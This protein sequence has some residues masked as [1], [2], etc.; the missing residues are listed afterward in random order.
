VLAGLD[1]LPDAERLAQLYSQAAALVHPSLHEGF[2]LTPLEAMTTGTPVIA[3]RSPGVTEVC[4][5]AVLYADPH[6]PQD[7]AAKL[8]QVASDPALRA[9]LGERGRRRAAEFSWARSAR[10]HVEA[11]TLAVQGGWG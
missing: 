3:A 4:G 8:T 10:A 2:G 7:L 6:D 9:D 11:Y 1:E 5:E